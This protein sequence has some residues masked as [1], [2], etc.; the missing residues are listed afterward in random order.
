M[1]ALWLASSGCESAHESGQALEP[2]RDAASGGQEADEP[3]VGQAAEVADA[4]PPRHEPIWDPL[5]MTCVHDRDCK[6]VPKS[7][8]ACPSTNLDDVRAALYVDMEC[9]LIACAPCPEPSRDPLRP[10]LAPACES[11]V[12]IARDLRKAAE[13]ACSQDAD[14]VLS[15]E[16]ISCCGSCSAAPHAY[17]ALRKGVS[18]ALAGAACAGDVACPTCTASYLPTPYCAADGHC[19]VRATP[20]LNGVPNGTCFAPGQR[21]DTAYDPGAVGCDCFPGDEGVCEG[22]AALVCEQARWTAVEDGP[23]AVR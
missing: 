13:T 4:G 3:D 19:A 16:R 5:R 11:G 18:V 17:R 23:C 9:P 6:L 7:C 8:C 14:C 20:A 15:P 22:R 12:C 21:A 1:L 10:W 2:T